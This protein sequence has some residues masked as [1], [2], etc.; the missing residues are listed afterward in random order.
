MTDLLTYI[1][2]VVV[3]CATGI[4]LGLMVIVV[5]AYFEDDDD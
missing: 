1:A 3:G 4:A 2:T 5:M